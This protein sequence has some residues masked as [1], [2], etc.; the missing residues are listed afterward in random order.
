MIKTTEYTAI[1]KKD[2]D[3]WYGWV[4]EI[5]GANAQE[6]TREE[7]IISLKEAVKDILDINRQSAR[8]SAEEE[9][10]EILLAI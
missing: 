6:K 8:E 9:F 7:L 5:P 4:E 2:S 3:W 1:V 10:E